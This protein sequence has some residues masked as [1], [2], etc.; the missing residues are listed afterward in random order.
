MRPACQPPTIL[1][2]N[3][4]GR[5][6]RM[7]NHLRPDQR[8]HDLAVAGSVALFDFL[9]ELSWSKGRPSA[10]FSMNAVKGY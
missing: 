3:S 7:Q 5:I 2:V 8:H 4:A 1:I 6:R 9:L 10:R